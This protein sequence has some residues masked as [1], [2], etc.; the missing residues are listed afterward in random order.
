MTSDR[1]DEIRNYAEFALNTGAVTP[2]CHLAETV[3]EL[4]SEVSRLRRDNDRLRM[5]LGVD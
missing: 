3:P 2:K 1:L 4:L 5:K